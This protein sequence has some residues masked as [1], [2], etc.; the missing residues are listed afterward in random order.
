MTLYKLYSASCVAVCYNVSLTFML[1]LTYLPNLP[2]ITK[3]YKDIRRTLLLDAHLVLNGYIS[4]IHRSMH[5]TSGFY[6]ITFEMVELLA[7]NKF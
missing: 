6:G 3:L 4:V 7:Q 5:L 1:V 2:R